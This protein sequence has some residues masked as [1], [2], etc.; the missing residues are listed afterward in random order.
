M[1]A[2][3]PK[4]TLGLIGGQVQLRVISHAPSGRKVLGFR[5]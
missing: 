1:S 5:H 2:I 4:R 3:G